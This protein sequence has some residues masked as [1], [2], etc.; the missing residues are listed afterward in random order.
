MTKKIKLSESADYSKK[1][2]QIG[3]GYCIREDQCLVKHKRRKNEH[4]KYFIHWQ[5]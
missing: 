2:N 1:E 3:C 5:D 4:C